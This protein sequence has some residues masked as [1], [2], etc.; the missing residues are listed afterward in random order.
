MGAHNL[1]SCNVGFCIAG[2][3]L[4]RPDISWV[5]QCC[6]NASTC[7]YALQETGTVLGYLTL[8]LHLAAHYLGGPLLHTLG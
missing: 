5:F 7:S 2:S 8:F 1:N 6:H 3:R 4:P